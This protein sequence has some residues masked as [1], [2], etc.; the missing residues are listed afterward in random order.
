MNYLKRTIGLFT[1]SLF[2]GF[3]LALGWFAAMVVV[4]AVLV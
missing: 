1:E 4:S 2:V 3:S